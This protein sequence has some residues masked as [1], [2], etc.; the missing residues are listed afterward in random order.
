M[1]DLPN[2]EEYQFMVGVYDYVLKSGNWPKVD[3][4]PFLNEDEE[5][6]PPSCIVDAISGE[7]SVYYRGE[8]KPSTKADCEGLEVTAVW[9]D[10]HIID[11]IMED[12]KWNRC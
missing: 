2:C 3:H 5:W 7:Y 6:P 10:N 9:A 12:D 11:R 4:R 8:I 1:E